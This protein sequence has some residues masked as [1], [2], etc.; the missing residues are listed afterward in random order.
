M[1]GRFLVV[2]VLQL[3]FFGWAVWDAVRTPRR[4]WTRARRDKGRWLALLGVSLV[5]A[6]PLLGTLAYLVV[7][8]PKLKAARAEP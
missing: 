8:R 2:A 4:L 1:S 7:A 6:V 5:L 3:G